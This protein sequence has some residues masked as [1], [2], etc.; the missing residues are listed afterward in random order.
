[1]VF[2]AYFRVLLL[3][4]WVLTPWLTARCL[5]AD[6]FRSRQEKQGFLKALHRQDAR[7]D[8]NE[9]MI[10]RPFSSP[11]YHTT[12]KGG[13]V[14]PTRDSF[15]YA[16]A[17]LDSGEP[18]RAE[19]AK[20]ILR[21]VISL[22]DQ[23]P[24][25]KTYGIWSWFMEE[26]LEQMSPPDW[27]WADFC[28]TQLLQV[29]LD[30]RHRLPDDLK[31]QVKDSI[32]HAAR[33]IQRRNV[34]P[35]YTNIAVMGTYVTLVAGE[36]FHVDEFKAYGNTR[37]KRFHDYTVERGSFREYN[38]P[39]YSRVAIR[40]LT[41]MLQ[42]VRDP[43]A[44]KLLREL[45]RL[46]WYHVARHFHSP[47][48]Q[49][50]GPHS[51][52]YSTLLGKRTLGFIQ[53]ATKGRV[54]FMPDEEA[55]ESF[56][57]HRLRAECPEDFFHYF[58]GLAEPRTETEAFAGGAASKHDIIGT[59]Y[60]HPDFVLGSVNI[61]DLWNQRRP[62]L[63]YWNTADGVVAMRLRCL[64]DG[65]DYA[66]ASIFTV[67]DKGDALGAVVFA[68]DRGDTHISLDRIKDATIEA[69]DLRIRLQFEG[70]VGT[71]SL[72]GKVQLGRPV[73]ISCGP[74]DCGLQF[75]HAVFGDHPIKLETGSGDDAAWVDL[76]LY[77]GPEKKLNF[78]QIKQAAIIL[79]LSLNPPNNLG[80]SE[81]RNE[82]SYRNYF[83]FTV[84]QDS[85]DVLITSWHRT[86]K[87]GMSVSVPIR[88]SGTSRQRNLASAEL[89][90]RNPWKA[91]P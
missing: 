31:Q 51:R 78:A 86:T 2:M 20:D 70:A 18:N 53:R 89:A 41:R 33:S 57:A 16:V 77:H 60:L 61:G 42:H 76:I 11:G 69:R 56:D 19:R 66:S 68:T 84:V 14:H 63:A 83:D 48:R 67:Q 90:G 59:T 24:S 38:S 50:A 87:R 43:E 85:R 75:A 46:A 34:G 36:L 55:F 9:K 39:T 79:A 8:P 82:L 45:N 71:L 6:L 40:E 17:L 65:Y 22:Q 49:W 13:H 81:R 15:E 27:N 12:L 58:T 74:I 5:G 91:S 62:L 80:A 73:C 72:P 3:S 37:L 7:Y 23:D 47:T 10:R 1:M 35:G 88:P 21:K 52:C 44:Q 26:P 29:A 4:M 25:S 32:V 64:H 54:R 28:G 30:H